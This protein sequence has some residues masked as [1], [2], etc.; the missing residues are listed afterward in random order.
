MWE[1]VRAG[2]PLMWPII[3]CSITA[4]AIILERLW[5]LQQAMPDL[6][7]FNILYALRVT[8]PLDAALLER[9]LDEIVRRHE[10][11]RTTI[12]VAGGRQ[13]QI[14]APQLTVSLAVD[15]L[16]KLP[17]SKREEAAH[18][19]VQAELTH[20]FDL[21]RGP[22]PVVPAAHYCCGGVVTDLH[23]RTALPRLYA[24]GENAC[25]GLHGANRLASNSLLEGVVFGRRAALAAAGEPAVGRV[26][27]PPEAVALRHEVRAFI[28]QHEHL[29]GF[30][31]GE[32]NRDFSR[33]MGKQ[34]WIGIPRNDAQTAS[35]LAPPKPFGAIAI[36]HGELSA[37]REAKR[38]SSLPPLLYRSTKPCPAPETSS[39]ALAS[40]FA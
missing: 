1:I 25:T 40:C 27:A 7:F 24:C 10:I 13:I 20:S 16:R 3:L 21:T 6:P 39:S 9:S 28:Q 19:L 5:T 22:V 32:F 2:G 29:M 12:G 4:A 37:P 34:G 35:P 17:T 18:R 23:G 36:P 26:T 15:D 11:L 8:S 14:I 30:S 31:R 38:L 33:A